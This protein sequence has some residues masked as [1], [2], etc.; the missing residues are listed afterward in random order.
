[1]SSKT[2]SGDVPH[3]ALEG[4]QAARLEEE[5][6]LGSES[7]IEGSAP[8]ENTALWIAVLGS[9]VIWF[10][11]LQTSYSLVMWACASGKQWSLHAASVLFLLLAAVPGWMG[12]RVWQSA[13]AHET[14]RQTAGGGRRR[15]MAMLGLMLTAL[16]L[17]LIIAQA[18]RSF[19][20]DACLE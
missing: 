4:D 3:T 8:R 6:Y 7:R 17:L 18:I 14:E 19:F 15:F 12:W 16:F 9:A 20:F 11:Q 10:L 5:G 2:P 1:M 13:A